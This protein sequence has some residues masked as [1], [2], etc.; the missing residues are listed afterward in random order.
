ML[1]LVSYKSHD[2]DLEFG[3]RVWQISR[4]TERVITTKIETSCTILFE[5]WQLNVVNFVLTPLENVFLKRVLDMAR[6]RRSVI[7]ILLCLLAVLECSQTIGKLKY[8]LRS[9]VVLLC[10]DFV[11]RKM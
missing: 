9:V 4:A 7:G 8:R 11:G 2:A 5:K 10:C 3:R 1:G 6:F